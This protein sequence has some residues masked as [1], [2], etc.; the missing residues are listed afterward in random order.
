MSGRPQPSGGRRVLLV[1][2]KGGAPAA[3]G[4]RGP[5]KPKTLDERFSR[6]AGEG[7]APKGRGAAPNA[8]AQ[9]RQAQTVQRTTNARFSQVRRGR[10]RSACHP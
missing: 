9:R 1:G 3:R 6:I 7:A 4:G 2:A 8:G 10:S 5:A